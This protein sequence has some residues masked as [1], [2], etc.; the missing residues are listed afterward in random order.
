MNRRCWSFRV[1]LHSKFLDRPG[2]SGS[3]TA[4]GLQ[5]MRSPD[6]DQHG[7]SSWSS[8][9]IIFCCATFKRSDFLRL[10]CLT[11]LK[12]KAESCLPPEVL[13]MDSVFNRKAHGIT[14]IHMA[15]RRCDKF[16]KFL[17]NF[18]SKF[19][20]LFRESLRVFRGSNL[21]TLAG[22][23]D[24]WRSMRWIRECSMFDYVQYMNV[25]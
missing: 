23:H 16:S 4:H 18:A 14:W 13:E 19:S 20:K 25:F 24:A 22:E 5:K 12:Q 2:I 6:F 1:V 3:S 11:Q 15:Q 8:S 17:A 10:K 7:R 21:R 9:V